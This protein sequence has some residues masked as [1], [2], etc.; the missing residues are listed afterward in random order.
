MTIQ[1]CDTIQPFITADGS[2]IRELLHASNSALKNQSLAEA[3]LAPGQCTTP[4]FHPLAEEIYFVLSGAGIIKI[5]GESQK[6]RVGDA[7]AIP[8]GQTHQ[9]CNFGEAD[10]VFLC[11][12][13]PA[14][15][16]E[17]TVLVEASSEFSALNL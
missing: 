8:N 7:I 9:I 5:E 16:H 13:A 10:L 6:I 12:C 15:S 3:T 11:V 17:D 4:H 14:Y 1:N 2:Q